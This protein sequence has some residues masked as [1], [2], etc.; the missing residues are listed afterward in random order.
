VARSL[1]ARI[2]FIATVLGIVVSLVIF[3]RPTH[4]EANQA[5]CADAAQS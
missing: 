2:A 4:G 5:K 1:D 3:S